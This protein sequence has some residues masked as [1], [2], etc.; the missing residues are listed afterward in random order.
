MWDLLFPKKCVGCS[1][2]GRYFCPQCT[3]DLKI[4]TPIC[5]VCGQSAI[6]GKTHFKCQGKYQL[7]GLIGGL[8]YGGTTQRAIKK[9]KFRFITDLVNE[10][11]GIWLE[12]VPCDNW[13]VNKFKAEKFIVVPIPLHPQREKWR[14]FNQSVEIGKRLAKKLKLKFTPHNLERVKK[15]ESQAE[16]KVTLNQKEIAK[17]LNLETEFDRKEM[18]RQLLK[19]KKLELRHKNVSGAFKISPRLQTLKAKLPG[20]NIILVDD[21]WTTGATMKECARVLKQVG[22]GEVWGLTIGR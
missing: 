3:A 2:K 9:L 6:A 22:V 14:G 10:L 7:D 11:V 20:K 5:P 17:I 19:Q 8:V 1:K 15:T 4:K 13:L 18:K 21:V 16:M 12:K